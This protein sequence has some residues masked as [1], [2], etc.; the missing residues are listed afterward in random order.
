MADHDVGIRDRRLGAALAVR[1]GAWLGT[2][3]L[4]PDAQGPGE[5]RD[6]GD[7]A[8]PSADG[9][10]VD[11]RYLEAEVPDRGV[12]A[13][14]RLAVLA[15][16]HIG[17]CSAHVEREDVLI[18]RVRGDVEGAGDAAGRAREDA[19]DRVRRCL[20]RRHQAGIGA[21]DVDLR[22]RA[23][24][25]EG[26]IETL[27]VACDARADV[28]V[29]AG[30]QRSF[31]LAELGNDLARERHR[32]ARV[33]RLDDGAD[34]AFVLA[35]DV[36]VDQ[37]DGERLDAAR[38]EVPDDLLDLGCDRPPRWSRRADPSVRPPLGCPRGTPEGRA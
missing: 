32:E 1:G 34:L 38:H 29:H 37:A 3:R 19:V 24:R 33:E 2:G 14:R 6:V 26:P 22:R 13:D 12:T 28:R 8:T 21:E 27:H 35:A 17:R 11:R 16:G 9:V 31:V 23:D 5:L 20:S 25:L 18:A 7:R 4:R 36:G 10:D 15:E 30:G